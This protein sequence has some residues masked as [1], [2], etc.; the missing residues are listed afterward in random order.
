MAQFV[1]T[2]T[3]TAP[4]G[5]LLTGSATSDP[6]SKVIAGSGSSWLGE[7]D[8]GDYLHDRV[9]DQ[10]RRVEY[11]VS[12]TEI[13]LSQ[14]FAAA[15]SNTQ[16]YVVK[17]DARQIS[18]AAEGGNISIVDTQDND[19]VIVDGSSL[20]PAPNIHGAVEPF[21]IKATSAASAYC[22]TTP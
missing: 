15:V 5:V 16:L 21:I 13:I 7:V 3:D 22:T 18:V 2:S 8:G 19:S 1:L 17:G 9:G 11:V 12:D 6:N 10:I 20:T 4:V 14:A